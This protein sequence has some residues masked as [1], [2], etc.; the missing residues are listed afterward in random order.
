V[1][2]NSVSSGMKQRCSDMRGAA[3]WPSNFLYSS[4]S[5]SQSSLR[6]GRHQAKMFLSRQVLTSGSSAHINGA[7]RSDLD[8]KSRTPTIETLTER[9]LMLATDL[10]G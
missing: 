5:S 10:A 2:V 1:D 7:R 9:A 6:E 4:C 3:G 8:K